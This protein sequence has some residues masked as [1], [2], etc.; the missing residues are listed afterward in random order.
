MQA[1]NQL[2]IT[3]YFNGAPC[4]LSGKDITGI[5]G[6]FNYESTI[7]DPESKTMKISFATM[8]DAIICYHN[9]QPIYSRNTVSLQLN[10]LLTV[11]QKKLLNSL[12][13]I[14]QS[15]F[16]AAPPTFHKPQ[17]KFEPFDSFDSNPSF[18]A[19]NYMPRQ[20]EPDRR[21]LPDRRELERIAIWEQR[22][23]QERREFE[24]KEFER[25]ETEKKKKNR[26]RTTRGC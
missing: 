5:F 21:V 23:E 12:Q 2:L 18:P 15:P 22:K 13:T 14:K 9:L 3:C 17:Q 11:N 1:D 20:K 4:F 19:T 8:N 26:K 10:F 25:K 16:N 6:P 24:T 7:E